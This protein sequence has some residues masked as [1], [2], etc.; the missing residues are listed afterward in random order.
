VYKIYDG[1]MRLAAIFVV[2]PFLIIVHAG[3][4]SFRGMCIFWHHLNNT[5]IGEWTITKGD[6]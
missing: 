3:L 6:G 1:I 5:D 4:G 2:L